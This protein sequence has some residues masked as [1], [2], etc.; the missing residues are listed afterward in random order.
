MGHTVTARLQRPANEHAGQQGVTFFVELG[1]QAFNHKTKQKEWSNYS[2][3]LFAK[4]L[5]R[6][7]FIVE[8]LCKVL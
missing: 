1:V 8:R 2:A 7:T 5:G 3:A 6:L 4:S